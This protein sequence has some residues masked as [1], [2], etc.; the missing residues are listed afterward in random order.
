M[1]QSVK[2]RVL[3]FGAI[4]AASLLLLLFIK[5]IPVKAAPF[6]CGTGFY[7]M[8]TGQLTAL[9]PETGTYT[10]IGPVGPTLTNAIGYNTEDNFIYG[11]R[12]DVGF[13]ANLVRIHDD[14]SIEN[15][16]V[17]AGLPVA[18]YVAGDFDN[19]GNLYIRE[20]N[21]SSE[22]WVVD[23]STNTAS[24]LN[25]SGVLFVSELV[26]INGFLYGQGGVGFRRIEIAT[27]IITASTPTGLPGDIVGLEAFGAG[28]AAA[29]DE[30]FLAR[31]NTGVIYKVD[32]YTTGS[33][34]FTPVLQGAIPTNNDGAACPTAQSPILEL[35]ANNDS[36]S[37]TANTELVVSVSGGLLSNDT[38]DTITVTS[39]TQ[40][41]NGSVVVNP[42]G[43]YTYTPNQ[44]YVGTD[45]FSYT[46][47]DAFGMTATA[48]VTITVTA[49]AVVVDTVTDETLAETGEQVLLIALVGIGAITA[50][51][52]T[53]GRLRRY[54]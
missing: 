44:D 19:S 28:W 15:L 5:P 11:I 38:G 1:G 48:S 23:V 30:L 34:V 46:I 25:L 33:P 41:A 7:Q 3:V 22:I 37:T 35:A 9:D 27:G 12:N 47:T 2:R 52:A 54:R 26:H 29:G 4:L 16:G 51:V 20:Y 43:S 49:G 53:A 50:G 42:D 45:T 6:T 18:A 40:P 17:P 21:A 39:N 14:G 10:N 13:E 36:A 8:L 31:N 32:D 24:V